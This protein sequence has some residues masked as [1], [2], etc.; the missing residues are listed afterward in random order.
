MDLS[1]GMSTIRLTYIAEY[2]ALI[3]KSWQRKTDG[4]AVAA[5]ARETPGPLNRGVMLSVRCARVAPTIL[6]YNYV[7]V[8]ANFLSMVHIFIIL[9]FIHVRLELMII[10]II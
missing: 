6:I 8:T 2:A 3:H 7:Y 9:Y 1:S 10:Q 5:R 4:P